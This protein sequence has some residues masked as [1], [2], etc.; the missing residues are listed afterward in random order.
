MPLPTIADKIYSWRKTLA[1]RI[2]PPIQAYVQSNELVNVELVS[3]SE[4]TDAPVSSIGVGEAN[5][6]VV[7]AAI[8]VSHECIWALLQAH[9]DNTANILIGNSASQTHV[10]V[11]GGTITLP[12]P[13]VAN[14]I[15]KSAAGTQVLNAIWG[16]K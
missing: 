6:A 12:V 13:N 3:T 15:A 4:V 16:V 1:E 2:D 14:I 9:P 10:L 5:I 11:P 8:T 7:A